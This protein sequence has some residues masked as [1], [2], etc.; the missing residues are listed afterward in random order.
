MDAITQRS[1][2]LAAGHF[3]G[4]R[5]TEAAEICRKIVAASP[6]EVE[7]LHLLALINRKTGDFTESERLFTRCL[8]IAPN[9]ADIR[10]NFGN[11]LVAG[12]LR[13]EAIAEYRQA[14]THDPGFRPARLALARQ[15][16][17]A[18]QFDAAEAEAER[19]IDA[20][21]N[22]AEA[23]LVK[24]KALRSTNRPDDA[25]AAYRTAIRSK[26]GY[27]IA[28]H[29]LGALLAHKSRSDEALVEL[30]RAAELGLQ[31]PE[32]AFNRASALIGLYEFDQAEAELLDAIHKTPAAIEPLRLLARLRFMRGASD[33]VT[34]FENSIAAVPDSV[35]LRLALGQVL[36]A[37]GELDRAEAVLLDARDRAPRSA[38]ILSELAA[39]YQEA[40]RF[41]EALQN[42]R[43][44]AA[45]AARTRRT[46]TGRR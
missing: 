1:L 25:E 19:L 46:A 36:N 16:N 13:E 17:A 27:S 18:E 21:A 15:L 31:G 33:Y 39:V 23:W 41:D 5:F 10:A 28:H 14:L 3:A 34:E 35:A 6:L 40:G 20:N 12:G 2:Q 22:D 37:A 24:G 42:A 38:P 30:D 7:A 11:L 43:L 8:G 45:A 9:R 32:L 26:P 4:G 44:A 29:N